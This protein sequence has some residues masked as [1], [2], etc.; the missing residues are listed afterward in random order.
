MGRAAFVKRSFRCLKCCGDW[1][2]STRHFTVQFWTA[3]AFG[4]KPLHPTYRDLRCPNP[5]CGANPAW[6][7][8][9]PR[10]CAN[11]LL[12]LREDLRPVVFRSVD[13]RGHEHIRYPAHNSAQ[14]RT[15][16]ERVDFPTLRSMTTFLKE[17]NA[18]W[19]DWQ[20]P[21]NDILDYDESHIDL[22]ALDTTDPGVADEAAEILSGDESGV[23]TEAEV[24][25][26]MAD[27]SARALIESH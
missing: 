12:P 15:G 14:P 5:D 10:V 20:V 8:P 23:A 7:E 2:L 6:F 3:A 13:D 26:F 24:A 18:N 4:G 16:E 17:Q 21:L 25:A 11:F 22:P 27:D 1:A 19:A 9:W